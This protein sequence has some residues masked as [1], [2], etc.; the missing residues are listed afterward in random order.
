[1]HLQSSSET[2]LKRRVQLS[3]NMKC[4]LKRLKFYN[5]VIFK[6]KCVFTSNTEIS[7][8]CFI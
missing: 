7:N 5:P 8:G 1:V 6:T 2:S 3:V 4:H